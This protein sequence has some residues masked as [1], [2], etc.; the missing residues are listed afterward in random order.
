MRLYSQGANNHL[1]ALTPLTGLLQGKHKVDIH[2]SITASLCSPQCW[3]NTAVAEQKLPPVRNCIEVLR[4]RQK[5]SHLT[6]HHKML[7]CSRLR[8]LIG[9]VT[10]N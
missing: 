6:S 2:S 8:S 5:L 10:R 1:R 4:S 9:K 3:E 7:L